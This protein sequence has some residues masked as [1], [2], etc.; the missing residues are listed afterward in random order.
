MN[1]EFAFFTFAG[2]SSNLNEKVILFA[3]GIFF[4]LLSIFYHVTKKEKYS[5]VFLLC[6]AVL[7][8]LFAAVLDP[9]L[10]VWDE[11]F[12]ALV[13]K[14]LM[15][16]PLMPTLYDD[17]VVNM[18]YD[19]W[20]RFHI[21]LHK[22]P[23]FMWQIALSYKIFGVNEFAL[24]LP[25]VFLSCLTVFAI[26]R[27]GK[28]LGNHSVGYYAALLFVSSFYLFQ[29][30]SG[31]QETDE[32]DISFLSYISLSLWSW[33]E[34]IHT[35]KKI[36]IVF[37]G[38][39]SGFAILCKWLVGLLVYLCWGIYS[40]LANKLNFKKYRDIILAIIITAIVALPWQLLCLHWY[41][42]EAK[43]AY[44]LN[45]AHFFETVDGHEGAW[46]Y[47]FN[48]ISEIFGI[49]AAYLLI[50]SLV[51]FY[52]KSNYKIISV[53]IISTVVFVYVFFS[54]IIT[55]M[56]SFTIILALP[57]Y[58]SLAFLFDYIEN[59][60]SKF[61]V[62]TLA[63]KI[64]FFILIVLLFWF[65]MDLKSL[66]ELHGITGKEH[67]CFTMLK[68]NKK[69]FQSLNLPS[70]AVIFNVNGRHY[71]EAMFYTGLPAYNFIPTNEQYLDLKKKSR[72]VALFNPI[73]DT[74]P[75]YLIND[76]SL[77]LIKDTLKLCE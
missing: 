34:Y 55:K 50:P 58:I 63:H 77:I 45:S 28:I 54:L 17:P 18:A 60:V 30:L 10:N 6:S 7:L 71:V 35:K 59:Q 73:G 11:R 67:P 36:W 33:I 76:P 43:A 65:R 61:K 12:H 21:W 64:I 68:H 62:S 13:A 15:N 4:I 38:V 72:R 23:L 53:A 19:N 16:H 52:I 3:I 51:I 41:P 1:N 5:L 32:N 29:L 26:Y 37:I 69:I 75:N 8:F 70:N 39:F 56:P 9:F 2:M 31:W 44:A 25:S 49:M 66:N 24:R 20:D 74:I 40:L 27:S 14:N 48:M 47:H 57:I 22:Q 42:T 46:Y